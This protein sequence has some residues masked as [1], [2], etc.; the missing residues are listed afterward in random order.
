MFKLIFLFLFLI[1]D[2]FPAGARFFTEVYLTPSTTTQRQIN[3]SF[4]RIVDSD[5]ATKIIALILETIGLQAS[6]EVRKANVPNAAAVIYKG[7]RYILYNPAFITAMNKA[8]GTPWASVAVLAHEIG[9][10]LNGH[11][12]DGK[13]SL[14]AIE[15]EADEFSGF[16]L[17]KMGASLPEAQLAMKLIA[18]SVATKT[19]PARMD[20]LLAIANGWNRA[21]DQLRAEDLSDRKIPRSNLPSN[22]VTPN[23][24]IVYDVHFSFDPDTRCSITSPN[25]LVKLI[26]D[27]PQLLG[28]LLPTENQAYPL[29]FH[30]GPADFLLINNDVNI[31]KNGKMLGYIVPD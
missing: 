9:H 6:F 21:D 29:A 16:A 1:T 8:A 20:R 4:S 14:P 3:I 25:N 11:T 26:N 2:H 10:H 15:L 22:A 5:G 7:R 28:K 30:I 24:S 13:G 12:L 18:H 17:R 23:V 19:H 31:I 27:Q